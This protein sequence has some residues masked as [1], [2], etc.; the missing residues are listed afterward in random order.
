MI[1]TAKRS[2]DIPNIAFD[3]HRR[4]I[5]ETKTLRSKETDKQRH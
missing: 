5:R 3:W 2:N 4:D 1:D